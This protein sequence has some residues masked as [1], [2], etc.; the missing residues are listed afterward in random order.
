MAPRTGFQLGTGS[1][2]RPNK[3]FITGH[4]TH[5]KSIYLPSPE[6]SYRLLP[7]SAMARSYALTQLPAILKND[8]DVKDY[9]SKTS[10][11]GF[12]K[13]DIVIPGGGANVILM[14]FEPG[15]ESPMHR[16]VS[17]DFSICVVGVLECVLDSGQTARLEAGVSF[18]A[19]RCWG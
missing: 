11:A 15:Y 19:G 10:T 13:R 3:R 7:T 1:S 16:T 2:L 12:S 8:Q 17:I 6:Q 14:D 18:L 5:G 4:D 9:T